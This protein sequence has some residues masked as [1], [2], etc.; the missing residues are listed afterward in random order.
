MRP[1]TLL[2]GSMARGDSGEQSDVDL[3]ISESSGKI[4]SER[5]GRVEVQYTPQDH[6]LK[7]ASDGSL[8]TAHLVFEAKVVSDPDGFF[9]ILKESFAARESYSVERDC[10]LALAAYLMKR[11]LQG[12]QHAIKN[13]RIAWCVRTTLISLLAEQGHFVFSPIH[14]SEIY[15]NSSIQR[16]LSYRR[17]KEHQ[18]DINQDIEWFL[19]EFQGDRYGAMSFAELRHEFKVRGNAVGMATVKSLKQAWHASSYN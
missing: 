6:L 7:M 17:S 19:K 2:Y 4:Y 14:L 9:M 5:A 1:C 8:F 15:P 10:A 11:K 12:R 3:L 13:K 16:L 18:E